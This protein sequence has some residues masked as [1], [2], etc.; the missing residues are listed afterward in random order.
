ML[1]EK[2]INDNYSSGLIIDDNQKW[3][4]DKKYTR[5]N[6]FVDGDLHDFFDLVADEQLFQQIDQQFEMIFIGEVFHVINLQTLIYNLEYAVQCLTAEGEIL[7]AINDNSIET[8]KTEARKIIGRLQLLE[9]YTVIDSI[10]Y[11]DEQVNWTLLRM[12]KKLITDNSNI[13]DSLEIGKQLAALANTGKSLKKIKSGLLMSKCD[14]STTDFKASYTDNQQLL[15]LYFQ[16]QIINL[17]P[18]FKSEY[19]LALSD[20]VYNNRKALSQIEDIELLKSGSFVI[21]FENYKNTAVLQ[22]QQYVAQL[23]ELINQ[24]WNSM[25]TKPS[26]DLYQKIDNIKE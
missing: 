5:I 7:I 15:G 21:A 25:Q 13:A 14:L 11:H 9:P 17:N 19:L 8:A 18:G 2:L 26:K 12:K 6:Q 10:P 4:H 3:N 23:A 24:V 22:D 16:N 20:L 1:L